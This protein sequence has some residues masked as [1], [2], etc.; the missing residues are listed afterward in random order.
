[1]R[2]SFL[3][4]GK[5]RFEC[6]KFFLEGLSVALE[7]GKFRF[8]ANGI[9]LNIQKVLC[10]IVGVERF[11]VVE[12]HFGSVLCDN[13]VVA[14][15]DVVLFLEQG[16]HFGSVNFDVTL[17]FLDGTLQLVGSFVKQIAV[18]IQTVDFLVKLLDFRIV[19]TYRYCKHAACIVGVNLLTVE[20]NFA[21][22]LLLLAEH[23]FFALRL[24]VRLGLLKL[25]DAI[26]VVLDGAL[27]VAEFFLQG[28]VDGFQFAILC[29]QN[30]QNCIF[31]LDWSNGN[32]NFR[33]GTET[34]YLCNKCTFALGN[35]TFLYGDFALEF[36]DL[37]GYF[38]NFYVNAN[39]FQQFANGF[40]RQIEGVE[41]LLNFGNVAFDGVQ[42]VCT[43]SFFPC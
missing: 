28:L 27:E 37:C 17:D 19:E 3:Q 5:T 35:L 31:G 16:C 18:E 34:L 11:D 39:G 2:L 25:H 15:D 41:A 29:F 22:E 21:L 13:F 30:L 10:A 23:D 12:C 32:V 33:N 40:C 14:V 1:M 20:V 7:F 36:F 42:F 43:N 38:V 6:C 4:V 8:V 9:L 24:Q 26:L